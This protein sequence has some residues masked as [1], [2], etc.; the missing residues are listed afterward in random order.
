MA[1]HC[2]STSRAFPVTKSLL[3]FV[4]FQFCNSWNAIRIRAALNNTVPIYVP[5]VGNISHACSDVENVRDVRRKSDR[6]S[7]LSPAS[8]ASSCVLR[9]Y[10]RHTKLYRVVNCL[11]H[12][13]ADLA[14][15][16]NLIICIMAGFFSVCAAAQKVVPTAVSL[17]LVCL[18]VHH[19]PR[20]YIDGQES[21]E[22]IPRS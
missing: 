14:F 15:L 10:N 7:E 22:C 21:R 20:W 12:G 11:F 16:L 6:K 13:A 8:T 9:V 4:R 18:L 17:L 1:D 3:L 19:E 5:R 2:L